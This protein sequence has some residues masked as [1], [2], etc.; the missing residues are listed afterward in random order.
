MLTYYNSKDIIFT[1]CLLLIFSLW[2]GEMAQQLRALAGPLEHLS[3]V[4]GT[5]T[6]WLH[7]LVTPHPELQT[8]KHIQIIK[9]NTLN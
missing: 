4:P 8:H 1:K 7:L 9:L 3:L 5:H 2:F 6:R